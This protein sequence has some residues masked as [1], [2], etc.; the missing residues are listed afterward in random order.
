MSK[1][2][3]Y[4]TVHY[5]NEEHLLKVHLANITELPTKLPLESCDCFVQIYLLP[6]PEKQRPR[7]VFTTH[8]VKQSYQP[9]FDCMATFRDMSLEDLSKEEMVF[10]VYVN[11]EMCFIGGVYYPLPS[12]S[13]FGEVV[14]AEIQAFAEE[15]NLKV[16][17]NN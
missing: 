11:N 1:A 5:I 6:D 9:V 15:V 7:K 16:S 12:P 17:Q 10:R 13:T 4:F 8:V 2:H 3:I 14:G